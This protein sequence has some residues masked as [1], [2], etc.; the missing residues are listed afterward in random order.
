MILILVG[1]TAEAQVVVNLPP[2]TGINDYD[3]LQPNIDE[4][5]GAILML[6]PGAYQLEFSWLVIPHGITIQGATDEEGNLLTAIH[7]PGGIFHVRAIGDHASEDVTL[8]SIF[9][10]SGQTCVY[11][12]PVDYGDGSWHPG[13]GNITIEGCWMENGS[14]NSI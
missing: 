2:P 3:I 13:G 8:R 14:Y 12:A 10:S 1:H 11:H 6:Q 4:N 7:G 9:M 5:P